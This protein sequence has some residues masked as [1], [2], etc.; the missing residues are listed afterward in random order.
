MSR[1]KKK[2]AG[3]PR[4]CGDT[5]VDFSVRIS[6]DDAA[7]LARTFGDVSRAERVRRLI[8]WAREATRGQEA[9][10]DVLGWIQGSGA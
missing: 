4:T 3:R 9:V 8:A 2:R 5:P 10:R 1:R 7:W 6:Q